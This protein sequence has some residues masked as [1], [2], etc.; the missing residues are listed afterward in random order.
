MTDGGAVGAEL[1][2]GPVA[3]VTEPG[4]PMGG[5]VLGDAPAV[6]LGELERDPA[7]DCGGSLAERVVVEDVGGGEKGLDG[8]H[9]PVD[10]AVGVEAGEFAVPGVDEH[11]SLVVPEPCEPGLERL[12]EEV[13]GAGQ[14]RDHGGGGGEHDEGVGVVRLERRGLAGGVEAVE[15]SAVAVVA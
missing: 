13:A 11:R 2:V 4:L 5:E 8:V 12:L 1:V 6:R 10:P 15:P 9:V 7:G 14:T 3:V